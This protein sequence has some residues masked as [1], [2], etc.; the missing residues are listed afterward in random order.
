[1]E[2]SFSAAPLS[3][4][5][6]QHLTHQIVIGQ[7]APAEKISESD[8]ASKLNVSTN[9]LR[10]ALKILESKHLV[11]VKPRRGTWVCGVS[12]S[13]AE[14]L[15]DFLF[16][17]FAELAARAAANW[18]EGELEKLSAMLPVLQECYE[19]NDIARG[20]QVVFEAL[21]YMLVFA[22]NDYM[23]KTIMDFVPLLQRYSYLALVEQ[24]SE[25]NV[26]LHTFQQLLTHV[27]SRNSEAAAQVILQY[28][29]S[30]CEIVRGALSKR[31][32][33][34]E[35]AETSP[36]IASGRAGRGQ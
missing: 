27:I 29:K 34:T 36:H 33:Q 26:S 12:E 8:W 1:M 6:T 18:Q 28:G 23:A 14:Q 17:L 13:Q 16:T 25:L 11:E 32:Q 9:S 21:P 22:R 19:K 7:L 5:I 4:Q 31:E 24:T 35:E 30:Q 20:H 2:F 3:E 15:Y 10:E